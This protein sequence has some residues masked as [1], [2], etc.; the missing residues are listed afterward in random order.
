MKELKEKDFLSPTG[1]KIRIPLVSD[2]EKNMK[3]KI[4]QDERM[5]AGNSLENELLS[6]VMDWSKYDII[7]SD[8]QIAGKIVDKEIYHPTVSTTLKFLSFYGIKTEDSPNPFDYNDD[9]YNNTADLLALLSAPRTVPDVVS[10][11]PYFEE[12]WTYGEGN[13]W[14]QKTSEGHDN[15]DLDDINFM[16]FHRTPYDEPGMDNDQYD[17]L[18]SVTV[19]IVMTDQIQR[20]TF[21]RVR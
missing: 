16:W 18:N 6:N 4:P 3:L 2:I 13:T 19:D 15:K 20:F 17:N 14:F 8:V 5:F 7:Y 9:G 10:L 11:F 12:F 1:I 21:Y